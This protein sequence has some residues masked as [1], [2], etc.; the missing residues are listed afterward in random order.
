[1][2]ATDHIPGVVAC[3]Q[4]D[5]V[6]GSDS[7]AVHCVLRS[8]VL[9]WH[10][11]VGRGGRS[12]MGERLAEF[13]ARR[14]CCSAASSAERAEPSAQKPC[15]DGKL[16]G[17]IGQRKQADANGIERSRFTHAPSAPAL[18]QVSQI[19]QSLRVTEGDRAMDVSQLR[20]L[21]DGAWAAVPDQGQENPPTS[22]I[23]ERVDHA[24][25]S[26]RPRVVDSLG[27]TGLGWH[28]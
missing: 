5:A 24:L 10:E 13:D 19:D 6:G 22:R 20:E 15:Q 7:V 23:S 12:R 3:L 1:M 2:K 11:G 16:P 17:W 26:V 14:P 27:L 21:V 4:E 25:D 28:V 8:E 9:K 18:V